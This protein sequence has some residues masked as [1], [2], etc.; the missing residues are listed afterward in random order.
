MFDGLAF[1]LCFSSMGRL[2]RPSGGCWWLM[3]LARWVVGYLDGRIYVCPCK[4]KHKWGQITLFSSSAF[5][6]SV[7]TT[8]QRMAYFIVKAFHV[9]PIKIFVYVSP[10]FLWVKTLSCHT[11]EDICDKADILCGAFEPFWYCQFSFICKH[12]YGGFVVVLFESCK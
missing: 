1:S 10:Y 7:S 2:K 9:R 4:I 5:L 6:G 12:F 8:T 3:M 11:F